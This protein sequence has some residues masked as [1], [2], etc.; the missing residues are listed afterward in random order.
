MKIGLISYNSRH[1]KTEQVFEGL[2]RK[3]YSLKF[4]L[5][6][7][8]QF[9]KRSVL[10]EHRPKQNNSAH[11]LDIA[12]KH[13]VDV[14]LL[15]DFRGS[16]LDSDCDIYLILGGQILSKKAVENK[17]IINAHPG[18]LPTTR[19]LDAFK[20]A[21]Y[22]EEPLGVTLHYIDESVDFGQVISIRRTNV[23][24]SDSLHTLA[25]RHYENEIDMLINFED[26]LNKPI[27]DFNYE[28]LRTG[29]P[30]KRMPLEQEREMLNKF[31]A[32]KL[33]FI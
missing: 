2:I 14:V 27:F 5:L 12:H 20:W 21:I 13:G 9:K 19:G 8:R 11:V 33:K 28:L 7:F 24:G 25:R 15:E 1:L 6:P 29:Q 17:R 26:L 22:Y 16:D 31:E 32:Y 23:Y 18:V 3:R 30:R 10:F 4:Y